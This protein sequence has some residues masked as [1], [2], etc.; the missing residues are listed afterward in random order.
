MLVSDLFKKLSFGELSNM[1]I[2]MDGSGDIAEESKEKVLSYINDSLLILFTRYILKKKSSVISLVQGI[3]EYPILDDELLRIL[4][5]TN[6][7]GTEYNITDDTPYGFSANPANVLYVDCIPEKATDLTITYQARHEILT[8]TEEVSYDG[9]TVNIPPYLE[10]PLRNLVAS[11]VF[12]FMGGDVNMNRAI[13]LINTYNAICE[14]LEARGLVQ[15]EI[16]FYNNKLK[17]RGF[18]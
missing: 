7:K 6:N 13:E 2:G 4:V 18:I 3:Y 15:I 17:D 11:K 14:L 8:T 12:R 5:I 16:E 9:L 10:E 1:S